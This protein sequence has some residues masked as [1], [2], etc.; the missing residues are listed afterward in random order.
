WY[1]P[2]DTLKATTL[3]EAKGQWQNVLH[4]IS[5]NKNELAVIG[6]YFGIPVPDNELAMDIEIVKAI[7]EQLAEFIPVV[8]STLGSE[9]VLVVRKALGNDP[10]YDKEGKLVAHTVINSRLYPPLSHISDDSNETLSVSGC[11]DCLTAGIIYGIHKNFDETTCLSL[12]L[13]AASLSLVSLD[14]VPASLS[15]LCND[16]KC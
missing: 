1:E 5:P 10:F 7:A 16:I 2:T 4:F 15:S 9:G 3:F 6:K 11:G 14:A 13:K 12:A 8:I